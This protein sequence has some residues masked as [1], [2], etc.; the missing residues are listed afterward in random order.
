MKKKIF[1]LL[2]AVIGLL[3]MT[4]CSKD[5]GDWDAMKWEK[6]SYEQVPTPSYG[7][8]I[9]VPKLGGSYTFKCK[10]YNCI[11]PTSIIEG[12]GDK[13]VRTLPENT[14]DPE[15]KGGYTTAKTEG[16]T[17]TVTFAPNETQ[18]KRYIRVNV[19][20]GDIFYRFVFMQEP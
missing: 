20:A 13:S 19:S 18:A 2:L 7:K 8:A 17:L 11:W 12:D 1:T 15:T 3:S 4:S 5:D 6:T 9:S 16:N 10:N 14:G